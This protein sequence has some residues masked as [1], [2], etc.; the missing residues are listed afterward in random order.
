MCRTARSA[1][2]V[3]L[4]CLALLA[5][6]YGCSLETRYEVL[7]I[8][9]NDVPPPGAPRP[10]R[11]PAQR[12]MIAVGATPTPPPT[13]RVEPTAEG[14]PVEAASRRGYD[15][16]ADV[17][18]KDAVGSPDWVAALDQG[19]M[20]PRAAIDPETKAAEPLDLTV[21]LDP[22][23]PNMRVV[24]P[25]RPHTLILQCPDCHAEIFP[26][27]AGASKMTMGEIFAGKWCGRCHG[28]VAFDLTNC[29]RCHVDL[30]R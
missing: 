21:G 23:L 7:R 10:T 27:Q 6:G 26:M 15:G 12:R 14:P 4:L 25:H 5:P 20:A 16:T 19:L 8:V 24:F 1:A 3:L 18:P 28:K 2:G 13:P 29:Q 9:F 22:G 11:R 30:G 17:L